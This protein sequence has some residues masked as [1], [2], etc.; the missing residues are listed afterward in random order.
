MKTG[1]Q[2]PLLKNCQVVRKKKTVQATTLMLPTS[3]C[4]LFNSLVHSTY[5]SLKS[6]LPFS[7]LSPL[8]NE[9]LRRNSLNSISIDLR[10][11]LMQ[12]EFYFNLTHK[13]GAH[14]GLHFHDSIS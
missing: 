12:L 14:T 2:R 6:L 13:P 11:D 10:C 7:P 8:S 1:I 4:C 3:L 5:S 9:P